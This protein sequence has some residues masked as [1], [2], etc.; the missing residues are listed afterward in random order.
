VVRRTCLI[1]D[2]SQAFLEAATMRLEADGL[3]V[4]G[5]AQTSEAA[6][7]RVRELR[8]DVVLIDVALGEE[9]GFDLAWLL[10]AEDPPAPALI[11]ISTQAEEDLA[12]LLAGAP[13]AGFVTKTRLS[14]EAVERLLRPRR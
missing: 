9:R 1:V 14:A 4:V 3:T 11:M 12:D 8:P 6:L 2:D 10:A 13:V 5:V 7:R